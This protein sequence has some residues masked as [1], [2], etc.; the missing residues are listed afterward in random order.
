MSEEGLVEGRSP[1]AVFTRNRTV[2]R[3]MQPTNSSSNFT[4]RHHAAGTP[5]DPRA[6]WT[7]I[8]DPFNQGQLD[9]ERTSSEKRKQHFVTRRTEWSW[10]QTQL[11]LYSFRR[12]V[13]PP[14]GRQSRPTKKMEHK[15]PFFQKN[16]ITSST[17]QRRPLMEQQLRTTISSHHHHL[18]IC[19]REETG[20]RSGQ[21]SVT[22]KVRDIKDPQPNHFC[23][24][25]P[26]SSQRDIQFNDT[27]RTEENN[28]TKVNY[29]HFVVGMAQ[30][31]D[32]SSL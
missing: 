18:L 27:A 26:L 10:V 28:W 23:G 11:F 4:S 32:N 24:R 20:H 1:K 13:A 6:F 19:K 21:R 17:G 31:Q 5:T 15:V 3:K 25:E 8:D 16:T 30:P 29:I 9:K 2:R 22:S 12:P 14:I 7:L